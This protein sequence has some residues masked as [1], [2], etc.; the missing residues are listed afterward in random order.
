MRRS[1]LKNHPPYPEWIKKLREKE[2]LLTTRNKL[3]AAIR[4]WMA[5]SQFLE[6]TT[7]ILLRKTLPEAHIVPIKTTFATDKKK[8]LTGHL[9]TSPEVSMKKL[10]AAGYERIFEIAPVFRSHED[11][12][13]PHHSSEFF[14]LEWY[15]SNAPLSTIETD[16]IALIEYLSKTVLKT[17]TIYHKGHPITLK[18]DKW[19]VFSIK[20]V[21]LKYTNIDLRELTTWNDLPALVKRTFNSPAGTKP[22]RNHSALPG[23]H[24]NNDVT[25][26][27]PNAL[28]QFTP[29]E[30]FDWLMVTII[31]PNLP[32]EHGVLLTG[33]PSFSASCSK[34]TMTQPQY[35]LRTE[36][37]LGGIEIA[38]GFDELTD[39]AEQRRRI[40]AA[41]ENQTNNEVSDETFLTA[42]KFIEQASGIAVGLDRLFMLLLGQ[43]S[44]KDST[45]F[46]TD[47]LFLSP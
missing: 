25:I 42:L 22:L 27:L 46:A 36:A 19:Q 7:P 17:T 4:T 37:Y 47:E 12:T 45:L 33:Y 13:S 1:S 21:F 43:S 11:F 44:I 35:A 34:L 39:P 28:A 30:V 8:P 24:L 6:V 29:Q 14:L 31:E 3:L 38:N 23:F 5:Q 9:R 26:E 32:K 16:L 2:P 10:L 20:D 41:L 18:K 40:T 15:R